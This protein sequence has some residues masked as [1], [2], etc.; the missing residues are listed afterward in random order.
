MIAAATAPRKRVQFYGANWE[1]LRR[2]DMELCADGPAG[3]GKT[4]TAL[5]KANGVC[6]AFPGA[7]VLVARKTNVDL[8]AS[9]MVTLRTQ[10]LNAFPQVQYFG[11]NR[12]RPAA[13]QY[14]NGSEIVIS[15]LDK[16][17]KV[18]SAEY[19]LA[20][21]NE[22][23][24][25]D[26][27]DIEMVRSRLRNGRVPYQQIILDCN[28][29]APTHWLNQRMHTGATTRLVCRHT[30]NP[31]WYNHDADGNPTT[32]TPDGEA[33]IIGVL[34]GL[35]GVRRRRLL[36]GEWAAAEGMVYE[37]A[38][39]RQRCLLPRAK[40]ATSLR[41]DCGIDPTWPRYIGIDWGYRN[42]AVIKWYARQPDGELLVYRELYETMRLVEDLAREA[43]EVMGWRK[44][45]TGALLPTRTDAD[46]LPRE[47]IADHDAEDRATFERHFGM[48][49]YPAD[50]GKD[51]ISDGIQAVT[52]RLQDGRLRYL[53]GSLVRRDPLLDEAK[54]PASSV[55]EFESY[56]WDTRA[57]RPPK[58]QPLDENNHGMDVDRYLCRYF[59]RD[60]LDAGYIEFHAPGWGAR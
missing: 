44:G 6:I 40:Y 43:L 25:C 1:L 53:E 14:P 30:D 36:D 22:A 50:K 45:E 54:R 51:S 52:R 31:R 10:V 34:G 48:S 29:D 26:I 49:V 56:I 9:A 27:E 4:L 42:P 28:P 23:T 59:D 5:H 8:A 60:E 24:E 20:F 41:G 12:I 39:D 46:P 19:D 35:T 57:G 2:T 21:I 33:Y 16:P 7:R 3:T 13:F 17:D 55:E 37:D 58:E 15:G 38:W 18:K 11:G 47:I 32:L